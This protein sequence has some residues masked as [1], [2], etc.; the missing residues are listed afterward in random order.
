[1]TGLSLTAEA[2][3]N[4]HKNKRKNNGLINITEHQKVTKNNNKSITPIRRQ[5][6]EKT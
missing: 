4:S 3:H 1:M 2:Q 6:N 5:I